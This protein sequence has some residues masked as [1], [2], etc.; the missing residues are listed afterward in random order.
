M[1]YDLVN[2]HKYAKSYYNKIKQTRV[3][4]NEFQFSVQIELYTCN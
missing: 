1:I 2:F 4:Q 3:E